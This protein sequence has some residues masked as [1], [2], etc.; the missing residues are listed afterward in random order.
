MFGLA[1]M[2]G[3][4]CFGS[5]RVGPVAEGAGRPCWDWYKSDQPG[6]DET[7]CSASS[8]CRK[9]IPTMAASRA[10]SYPERFKMHQGIIKAGVL[11]NEELTRRVD[12]KELER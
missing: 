6:G 1:L 8:S 12:A 10:V 11:R 7:S 2:S 9:P 5:E 4:F 3:A